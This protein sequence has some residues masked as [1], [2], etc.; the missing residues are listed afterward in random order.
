MFLLTIPV[1]ARP[2]REVQSEFAPRE[3]IIEIEVRRPARSV[4]R[5]SSQSSISSLAFGLTDLRIIL[6][7]KKHPQLAPNQ[8]DAKSLD[9][10]SPVLT[11]IRKSGG[12]PVQER[13]GRNYS[14]AACHLHSRRV[15]PELGER[16]V[17]GCALLA[18]VSKMATRP[19]AMPIYEYIC[20][21]CGE[22][23][24]QIVLSRKTA[25]AC[26][27]C[28]SRRHSLQLSVFSA[29]AKSGSSGGSSG[30]GGGGMAS[31][32]CCGS[33]GCGCN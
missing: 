2:V 7:H 15:S 33:G 32:P 30:P 26:P 16:R 11:L 21:D 31:G 29:P 23:Y 12:W 28:E 22:R 1:F 17:P 20:D 18:F 5:Q 8:I 3:A 10:K 14:M 25:V 27:R 4:R 6:I 13:L 24:E 19:F 9:L